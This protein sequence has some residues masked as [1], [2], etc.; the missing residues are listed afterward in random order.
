MWR[1]FDLGGNAGLALIAALFAAAIFVPLPD[2]VAAALL[3]APVVGPAAR[4]AVADPAPMPRSAIL[5]FGAG[6]A[7]MWGAVP[8]EWADTHPLLI[9]ALWTLPPIAAAGALVAVYRIG[10]R[11]APVKWTKPL[12][13][14]WLTRGALIAA[15]L[16]PC[17]FLAI[18]TFIAEAGLNLDNRGLLEYLVEPAV[19]VSVTA[20]VLV[21][22]RWGCSRFWL[23]R[24]AG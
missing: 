14:R 16:F 23:E 7:I 4:W 18:G 19:G 15:A 20:L 1:R 8:T 9:P 11:Q 6:G 17:A 24:A 5:A 2:G 21:A 3:F 10:T 12:G 13:R 22:C